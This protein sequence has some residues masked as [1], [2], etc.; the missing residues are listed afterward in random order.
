MIWPPALTARIPRS[1]SSPVAC[2][3]LL[4]ARLVVPSVGVE[5]VA[6]FPLLGLRVIQAKIPPAIN[7][8]V[9]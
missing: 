3:L 1:L 5:E 9:T 6:G 2:S 8:Y 4:V 7:K